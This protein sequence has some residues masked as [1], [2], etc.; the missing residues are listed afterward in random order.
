RIRGLL[1]NLYRLGH[2]NV[3]VVAADGR[4]LPEGALF[5]RALVDAPCS[6]EG[7][8]RRQGGRVG[9][10]DPGFVAHVT[11]VQEALLRRAIA[12][13]RPGGVIVYSTCTVAPEENEGILDRVLADAPVRVEPIRLEAPHAPGLEGWE[14]RSFRP[15]V[16]D[17]WRVCPDH[18]DSG[19]LFMARLRRLPESEGHPA[20][21]LRGAPGAAPDE[22]A[23]AGTPD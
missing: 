22:K 15:E 1:G 18:L 13:V 14:G 10:R 8:L 19:G 17:A 16:R 9:P 12:L 3:L 21:G 5:D 20:P 2:P 6:A 4:N 7:N 11:E 23:P